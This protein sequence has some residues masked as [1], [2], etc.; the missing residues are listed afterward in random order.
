MLLRISLVIALLAG[1]AVGVLNFV[2]VKEKI[3][4]TERHRAEEQ[5][6]KETALTKLSDTEKKLASTEADLKT[7]KDTLAATEA[8]RDKAQAE[9]TAATKKAADLTEQLAKTTE[10]RN[11]AQGELA[12]YKATGVTPV[13]ILNFNKQ[14]KELQDTIEVANEE[15]RVLSRKLAKTEYELLKLTS[16]DEVPPPP[17]PANLRGKVV[18]SDPK[19]EFVVLDVGEDQ[20]VVTDGELLVNRD[21][22]LVAKI[23]VRTVEKNR[24]IAN[25]IP[26]WKLG[27]VLEGDSVFPAL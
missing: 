5:S 6:A 21:G 2:L 23:K 25:V 13:Q 4:T 10:E 14:I 12:A 8:Q 19:W 26:G 20:D 3:E 16:R 11:T 9:A 27:E 15:K 1:L 18:A 17:L 24:C 7:T 22:K